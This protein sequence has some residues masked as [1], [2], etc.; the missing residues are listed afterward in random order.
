MT[1]L[2]RFIPLV[3]AVL[4]SACINVPE[5]GEPLPEAPGDGGTKPDAGMPPDAGT[6]DSGV[7]MDLT[8]PTVTQVTPAPGSSQVSTSTQLAVLFSEPMNVSTVQVTTGPQVNLGTPT[9]SNGDTLLTLQPGELLAQNTNYTLFVDGR[10]KA[11]NLLTGQKAYSFSTTGP[12]PDTTPPTVLGSTP[13][14]AAVGVAR[15]ASITVVFSE[16]MDKPA[17]QAAFDITSPGGFNSGVFD[18]NAA[19]TE[20][21]FNPDTDFPYGAEV[22]WRVTTTAEDLAGNTLGSEVTSTFRVIRINTVTIDFNPQTSGS[23][24]APD[25]WKQSHFYSSAEVGDW[26]SNTTRRLFIGFTLDALPD[27]LVQITNAKLKWY[28][29]GRNGDP[30]GVL[31]RLLIERVYIGNQIALS[32]AET[33]NPEARVQYESPALSPPIFVTSSE[34]TTSGIFDVTSFVALDWQ[35]RSNRSSKRSQF[36]LRFE[37]PTDNDSSFDEVYSSEATS[38]KLAELEVTY[39]YP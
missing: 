5:V 38:P 10:D 35:D 28:I 37:V 19:G 26:S 2:K 14:A 25:Y 24:S 9:W 7:P 11:G 15:N 8:R 36:R 3:A 33:V 27:N 4:L 1:L 6:P 30:F 13:G 23:A 18:W 22:S 21:T 20:M 34:L 31:G 29:S 17:A 12:A 39:Q 16:P 32:T